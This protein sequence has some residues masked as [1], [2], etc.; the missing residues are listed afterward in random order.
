MS[1]RYAVIGSNS[2]SGAT[3]VAGAL[4]QGATVLGLSRSPEADAVFLPYKWADHARHSFRQVDLNLD[5]DGA[6]GAI[7]RFEPDYVVNFAAQ[8]MVAQS[9]QTPEH[10][11]LTN[12]VAMAQLHHRLRDLRSMKRFVQASTPEVYGS[13][14]G[15]VTEDAPFRPSTPYAISKAACDMNLLAYHAAFGFPCAFTR[16]ANVCGP[17]Q[18]LYRI[19]PKTILCILTGKKLT[20]DG[21]GSSV[22]SFVHIEDVV[23]GTLRV[24][25]QGVAGQAYH[26]ATPRHHTIREVVETICRTLGAS[27]DA[28]VEVGP[29][30]IGKDAA[31]LLDTGKARTELGWAPTRTLEDAIADTAAWVQAH[32]ATLRELPAEYRHQA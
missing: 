11:Y 13:T 21:G 25:R 22:R 29:E 27:F 1:E 12:T 16:S 24:A 4:R 5:P 9:W 6:A 28:C 26:L 2:F 10:W 19:I 7:R 23:D 8:G 17:A 3:F 20:L 14:A 30:R 15:L 18:A 32:L 31:Y